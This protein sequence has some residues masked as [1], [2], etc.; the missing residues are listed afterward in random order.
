MAELEGPGFSPPPLFP[1]EVQ[2]ATIHRSPFCKNLKLRMREDKFNETAKKS[3]WMVQQECEQ[4]QNLGKDGLK[5][6]YSI[7]NGNLLMFR[8]KLCSFNSFI[9]LTK[10][11]PQLFTEELIL[12][13]KEVVTAL[14][15]CC[16]LSEEFACVDNMA[17]L[18]IGELCGINENRTI[19]PAVDHCCKANFAFRRLYCK[20]LKADEISTTLQESIL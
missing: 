14:T 13:G 1:S 11:A 4:L 9:K 6:H 15:T 2:L 19:N 17:D 8:T 5:Y 16:T 18:D 20:D 3:L 10:R 7:D 12:L